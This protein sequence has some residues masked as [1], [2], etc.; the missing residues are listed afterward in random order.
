LNGLVEPL[1]HALRNAIDHGVEKPD[2]RAAA[3][4]PATGVIT[5]K[6][7]REGNRIEVS[8]R[9]DGRGLDYDAI[10]SRGRERGLIAPGTQP[11]Q[12]E[13]GNLIF[14]P[15]FSTRSEVTAVSGRGVGM[16][17]VRASIE[18]LKGTVQLQSRAGD[19]CTLTF[20]LPLSLTSAHALFVGVGEATYGLPSTSV[21]QVLYSDAGRVLVV[22]DQHAFE[23][24]GQVAPLYTL[25]QLLGHSS[26]LLNEIESR[27]APLVLV[28]SDAGLVAL[29]VDRALDSRQ[30]VIKGL[31]KILPTI[32]GI[33][34]AC[35]L[36]NGAVG[37]I[38]EVREL[39]R[40]PTVAARS[41]AP[42]PKQNPRDALR[43][44]VVDDSL[45]ARRT[46]AQLLGDCGFEVTVA[47]DG[48]DAIESLETHPADVILADME[49]P[50][51]NGLDLTAHLR[52]DPR[53]QGVPIVMI[54]SRA[55]EKHRAQALR[56]GV[57]DYVTKPY[58]EHDLLA[59]LDTVMT[60][61]NGP[62]Q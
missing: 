36:P 21:E 23:Y 54:T 35:V 15:G 4:K 51:M 7:R 40:R 50:R 8:C 48:L 46:L 17:V 6:F 1:L 27:P 37:V 42:E 29:A 47:V 25:A 62:L 11:S 30:I 45:S 19:G 13:L 43:A 34:G 57:T 58:L 53:F 38:I 28:Q 18:R 55:A 41:V 59:R 16:D 31:P 12:T 10:E 5:V 39:L 61:R 60:V 3:G 32:P 20:R 2:E 44:L 22:G 49:M 52:A 24:A 33:A 26:D 56:A 14:A 9:D